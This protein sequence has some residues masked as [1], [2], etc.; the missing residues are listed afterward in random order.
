MSLEAPRLSESAFIAG[1]SAREK[2][3][4]RIVATILAGV[5]GGVLVGLI[6]GMIALVFVVAVTS[7]FRLD[8]GSLPMRIT[9]LIGEDGK[10][11]G[12]ALGLLTLATATNGPMAATFIAVAA[13][14]AGV[15][16]VRYVTVTRRIRW[17]LLLSGMLLSFLIVGPLV[18]VGQMLDPHAPPAPVLTL[19]KDWGGRLGYMLGCVALLIPAAAAEEV[20]FRGWLLRESAAITRNPI[21]L[22]AVNGILFS[23]VHGEFSPDPFLTRALMGAG[24]VYMTLRLGGI[25]FS[26]GAHAA[27]NI[28]IVLFIQPLSL[29]A[30]PPTGVSGG[31]LA[32]DLFLFFSYV[33]MAEAVARWPLLRRL[34]DAEGTV[35]LPATAAA[36]QFS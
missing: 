3:V 24:F 19:S 35:D 20:V 22:M 1:L 7:G 5:V 27:N 33:L 23:A 36:E 12:S 18:L 2:N 31:S 10:T 6:V 13:A 21:F 28:M 14:I 9:A 8:L 30:P 25:E 29:K 17:R 34:S 11:I 32:Q 26:T 4:W 16:A 15:S